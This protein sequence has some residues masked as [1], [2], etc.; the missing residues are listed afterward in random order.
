MTK[1][2]WSGVFVCL[3]ASITFAGP[4][5]PAYPPPGGVTLSQAGNPGTAGGKT[6]SFSNFD[7]SQFGSLW[8]G[9]TNASDYTGGGI[10]NVADSGNNN[11]GNMH[12]VGFNATAGAY[13]WDSG[14]NWS[15]D[16]QFDGPVNVPTRFL[17]KFSG[18]AVPTTKALAG[19]ASAD[20]SEEV[21]QITGNFS[22]NFVF[23]ANTSGSTWTPV[24]DFY[25]SAHCIGVCNGVNTSADFG[26]WSTA[27][28]GATPEPRFYG[29]VMVGMIGLLALVRRRRL[30]N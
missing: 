22:G 30:M 5:G 15:F 12:F 14:A 3:T 6:F 16:S 11:P 20:T 13:E 8:W 2:I 1:L 26:F 7:F 29:L 17:L 28:S 19:I 4:T 25:N 18:A 23:E 21:A 27:S 24:L 9:P 10:E